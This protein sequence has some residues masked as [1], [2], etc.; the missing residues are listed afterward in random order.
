MRIH[1]SAASDASRRSEHDGDCVMPN[2]KDSVAAACLHTVCLS[3]SI[4]RTCS[5]LQL[6]DAASVLPFSL[7]FGHDRHQE[8]ALPF[9]VL[10]CC[11]TALRDCSHPRYSWWVPVIWRL[12]EWWVRSGTAWE[13][14]LSLPHWVCTVQH[15]RIS[16]SG[17]STSF[18]P[19]RKPELRA[20]KDLQLQLNT[21]CSR[22]PINTCSRPGGPNY[23]WGFI[24]PSYVVPSYIS[25]SHS[26]C[27]LW[28]TPSQQLTHYR[29]QAAR[30]CS[31]YCWNTLIITALFTLWWLT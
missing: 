9:H 10:L 8:A 1:L 13:S 15:F 4:R 28:G 11:E 27:S 18:C 19:H 16:Y 14:Q 7:L 29:L 3:P 21:S 31:C 17:Y 23:L 12:G 24:H 6:R 2:M 26:C 22:I 5:R 25:F 30:R 20:G